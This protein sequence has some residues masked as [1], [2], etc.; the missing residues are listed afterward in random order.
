MIQQNID[1]SN[2]KGVS[3]DE[4]GGQFFAQGVHI[5]KISGLL[6]GQE[7]SGIIPIPIFYCTKCN[8]V[9]SEFLPHTIK[10]DGVL[11]K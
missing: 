10:E 9:N 3:C 1:I 8:H 5:R 4:C 7:K 2:T 11:M 6:I